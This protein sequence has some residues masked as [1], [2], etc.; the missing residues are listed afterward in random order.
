MKHSTKKRNVIKNHYQQNKIASLYHCQ[1]F[2]EALPL[3]IIN[4]FPKGNYTNEIYENVV[5]H[6]Y[7][8]LKCK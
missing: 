2:F 1:H 6:K 4:T 8:F 5:I 7:R 3:S